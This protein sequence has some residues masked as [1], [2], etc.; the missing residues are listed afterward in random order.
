[1][2]SDEFELVGLMNKTRI[3]TKTAQERREAYL[4]AWREFAA[5]DEI[6]GLSLADFEAQS[7]PV[8]TI[9]SEIATLLARLAGLRRKRGANDADFR[10]LAKRVT[11]GVLAHPSHGPDSPLIRALGYVAESER[12]SGL[13]RRS[14]SDSPTPSAEDAA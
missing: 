1:M 3:N 10:K 2:N 8:E 5:D 11:N 4:R 14:S 12:S 6:A 9:R 7:E 13:T